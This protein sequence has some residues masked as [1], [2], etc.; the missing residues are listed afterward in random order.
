MNDDDD[1]IELL[2]NRLEIFYRKKKALIF[3][4][5]YICIIKII[6][7]FQ[8]VGISF[9]FYLGHIY[10]F[11]NEKQTHTHTH[12]LFKSNYCLFIFHKIIHFQPL[13]KSITR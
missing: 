7:N 2:L 8:S 1:E 12:E 9:D 4:T 13:S 11:I 5:I 10:K 6:K 3:R